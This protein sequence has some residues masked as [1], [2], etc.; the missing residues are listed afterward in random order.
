MSQ[1]TIARPYAKAVFELAFSDKALPLWSEMLALAAD[2]ASDPVII[3]ALKNPRYDNQSLAALFM[4]VGGEKFSPQMQRF[5]EVLAD[6][7]RLSIL[8]EVHQLY[9]E[10]RARAEQRI[11]VEITSAEPMDTAFQHSFE[12]ALKK[13]LNCDVVLENITDHSILGGA[14]IRAND[15]VIDGS[16]RGRLAKLGDAMGIS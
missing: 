16:V 4:G 7:K 1:L 14:I 6:F 2:I 15:M 3:E 9:E 5:L 12:D 11:T 13:R 10:L 8:P